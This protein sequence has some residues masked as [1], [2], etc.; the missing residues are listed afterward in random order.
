MHNTVAWYVV[1]RRSRQTS[2]PIN[3]PT[4]SISGA[5]SKTI[6]TAHVNR[7]LM[8]FFGRHKSVKNKGLSARIY[9]SMTM[10]I[11][12]VPTILRDSSVY[13]R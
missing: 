12:A 7:R 1:S 6:E 4:L 3:R 13:V 8:I 10:V 11:S 5:F 2:L 9:A